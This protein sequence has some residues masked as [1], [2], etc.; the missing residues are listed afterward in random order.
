MD[1][2]VDPEAHCF[3]SATI[4]DGDEGT[5]AQGLPFLAILVPSSSV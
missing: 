5:W 1:V 3:P 4:L 2:M